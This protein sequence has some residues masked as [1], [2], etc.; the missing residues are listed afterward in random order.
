MIAWYNHLTNPGQPSSA[1]INL[2]RQSLIALP[3][4]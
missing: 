1:D 2:Y 4:K 3:L